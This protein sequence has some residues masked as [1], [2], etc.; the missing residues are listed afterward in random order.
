M[1]SLLRTGLMAL[2]F[3]VSI[4]AV[5]TQYDPPDTSSDKMP[6]GM[7]M[8]PTPTGSGS[9]MLPSMAVSLLAL[10]VSFFAV[11]ERV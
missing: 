10:I 3:L 1:G 2:C 7:V 6:P 8:A 11:R 9:F 5:A 4:M